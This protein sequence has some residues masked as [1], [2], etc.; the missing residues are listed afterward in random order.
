M[1]KK[2]YKL[3]KKP[4]SPENVRLNMYKEILESQP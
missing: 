2:K 3:S 1:M 4:I